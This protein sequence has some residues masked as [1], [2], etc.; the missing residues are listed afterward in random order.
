MRTPVIYAEKLGL[1]AN[2]SEEDIVLEYKRRRWERFETSTKP[3][4]IKID[5]ALGTEL[6]EDI[7]TLLQ[8]YEVY[9]SHL[10]DKPE[11]ISAGIAAHKS[12][13]IITRLLKSSSAFPAEVRPLYLEMVGSLFEDVQSYGSYQNSLNSTRYPTSIDSL[14]NTLY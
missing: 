12:L 5:E 7:E 10:L 14:F 2:T 11:D 13:E 9:S 1:A 8:Q 3:M 4:C 6:V